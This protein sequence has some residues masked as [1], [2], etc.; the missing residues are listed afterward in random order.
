MEKSSENTSIYILRTR[1]DN[2]T[3]SEAIERAEGFLQQD[4]PK[5]VVTP[6]PE[7]LLE[8]KKNPEYQDVLNSA[9]LSLPDGFGLRLFSSLRSTV[10]GTDFARE[11]LNIANEQNLKV[12]AVVREDGL[13]SEEDVQQALK[14]LAPN[15]HVQ[16]AAISKNS[17]EPIQA[18]ADIVLVGLGFPNQELWLHKNLSAVE[19]AKIGI[20]IGGAFDFWTGSTKR[21]PRFIQR[22]G[23]EW[24][25]RLIQQPSR[26]GRIFRAVIVFPFMVLFSG[27]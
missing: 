4:T 18:E 9:D 21:A 13:S 10:T 5:L 15:A 2:V 16:V 17:M 23:L 14:C 25:W 20:G 19:G 3:F 7:I 11:L 27:K 26:I 12:L 8:A 6:N 24:L 22:L 1:L